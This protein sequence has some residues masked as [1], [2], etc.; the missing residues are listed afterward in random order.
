MHSLDIKTVLFQTIQFNIST[1]F[2]SICPI[3]RTLSGATTPG[4]SELGSD[5]NKEVLHIPQSS[6]ITEPYHQII[7]CHIRTLIGGVLPLC[8]GAVSVFYRPSQLGY[9]IF[10]VY[11]YMWSDRVCIYPIDL[12]IG[13]RW[14]KVNFFSRYTSFEF[15]IPPRLKSLVFST[16]YS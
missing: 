4:Q 11:G 5:G 10:F 3:D 14:S 8:R 2:S 1:Q 16:I 7:L 12:A 9:I 13:I 6:R 15:R